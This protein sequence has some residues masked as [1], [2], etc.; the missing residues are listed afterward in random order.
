MPPAVPTSSTTPATP[1]SR[2]RLAYER[3][4]VAVPCR[5]GPIELHGTMGS[6]HT[7]IA[8]IAT[9]A[10]VQRHTVYRHFPA[11][12]DLFA[13]C[14]TR[15]WGQYPGAIPRGGGRSTPRA[16]DSRQRWT[17]GIRRV[18]GAVG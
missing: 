12:D 14:S 15:Y 11:A 5:W 16:S 2:A 9:L 8:G 17:S 4:S 10:G 6:A 3:D 18:R 13:A 1:R 7:T